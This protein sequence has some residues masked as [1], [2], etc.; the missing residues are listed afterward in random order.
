MLSVRARTRAP[1][2]IRTRWRAHRHARAA[3][4]SPCKAGQVL[5]A[6]PVVGGSRPRLLDALT[7]ASRRAAAVGRAAARRGAR[8][9]VSPRR[10]GGFRARSRG[11]RRAERD[12]RARSARARGTSVGTRARRGARARRDRARLSDAGLTPPDWRRSPRAVA[13]RGRSPSAC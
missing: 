7:R 13:Y 5:V 12:R 2:S 3:A 11:A 6:A 1:Q 4:M 10:P 8:A 9:A